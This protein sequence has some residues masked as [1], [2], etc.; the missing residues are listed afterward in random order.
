[1]PCG[2]QAACDAYTPDGRPLLGRSAATGDRVTLALG[3][4][5]GGFKI[6][7][8]VGDRL[9]RRILTGSGTPP[10]DELSPYWPDRFVAA[11]PL[12]PEAPYAYL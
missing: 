3:F 11:R 4:S 5:G 7:P 1:M 10:Q 8:M 6:S 12:V 9:A 2:T